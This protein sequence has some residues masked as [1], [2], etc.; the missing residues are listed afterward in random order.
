[1]SSSTADT[2]TN[3]QAVAT[4]IAG[5]DTTSL[6]GVIDKDNVYGLNLDVPE[7]AREIIKSWD[8]RED[9]SKFADSMV[10][11]QV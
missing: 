3:D 10:D 5:S 8:E 6:W 2:V 9:T 4:H 7:Q 11:D 1:M